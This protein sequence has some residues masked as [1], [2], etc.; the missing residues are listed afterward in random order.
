MQ[1]QW[2]FVS[3][4]GQQFTVQEPDVPAL[5]QSGQIAAQTLMWREGMPQWMPA[6][7][8]FPMLFS[9]SSAA[10]QPMVAGYPPAG[11]VEAE[12]V[13]PAAATATAPAGRTM[14]KASSA[15]FSEAAVRRLAAPLVERKGWIRLLGVLSI[16]GGV[17]ALPALLLGLIPIF[18]GL[19]LMKMAGHLERAHAGGDFA[20]LE[21]AQRNSAKFFFLQGLFLAIQLAITVVMAVLVLLGSGAAILGGLKQ[22]ESRAPGSSS[23][24]SAP[25]IDDIRFPDSPPPGRGE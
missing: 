24:Q 18:A 5:A 2:L 17:L 9:A 15:S 12:A 11:G 6:I 13:P 14:P 19:A 20:Q 8:V 10:T 23:D 1:Q 25:T 22:L 4:S 16:I 7:S 3:S 21:E